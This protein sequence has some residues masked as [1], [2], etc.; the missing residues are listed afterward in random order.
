MDGCIEGVGSITHVCM[1]GLVILCLASKHMHGMAW[2]VKVVCVC[3]C[4]G[5]C[6]S[7]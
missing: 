2:L 5:K 4:V 6:G 7:F 3:V 1:D